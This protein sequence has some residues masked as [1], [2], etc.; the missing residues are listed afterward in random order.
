[1]LR[2]GLEEAHLAG[3]DPVV[4]AEI[5]PDAQ[6]GH[7]ASAVPLAEAMLDGI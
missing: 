7:R 5:D 3:T 1:M 6:T 2:H 4:G